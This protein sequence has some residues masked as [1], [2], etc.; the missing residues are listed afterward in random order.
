MLLQRIITAV[1]LLIV[2]LLVTVFL[3]P[4]SFRVF[5]AIA[6]AIAMWEWLRLTATASAARMIALVYL[7]AAGWVAI[8][9]FDDIAVVGPGAAI[10]GAP[11]AGWMGQMA[12]AVAALGALFWTVVVPFILSRA[13]TQRTAAST[14]ISLA[15]IIIVGGSAL[16]LA[17]LH[18]QHGAWFI[19]SFLAV[20]WCADTF[21]YF[22]GKHF[23]GA[24]L[25][26]AI[27]PGKT[28]SGAICG[29]V[30][31]VIWM[32]A[33]MFI[34]GSF[35]AYV[36]QYFPAVVVLL[37]GAVLAIYSMI[38]DLFES[39]IKRRAGVK[40]SSNLLPGHGGFWDRFDSI[41]SVT[42][43]VLALWM[44]IRHYY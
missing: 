35:A 2:L 31:A 4:V 42:P 7:I 30:A 43:L 44:L 3:P 37:V 28:R 9:G 15:A 32:L 27:S 33:T 21:A 19:F 12:T 17:M 20:I 26:P 23:G 34:E 10:P 14:L 1:V 25:A 18:Q 38:G 8:S 24:K 13:D 29:L 40:D 6:S 11:W 22:G 39:L 16:A 41:L 5:I 36:H